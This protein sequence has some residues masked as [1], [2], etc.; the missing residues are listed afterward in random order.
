MTGS[1][2]DSSIQSLNFTLTATNDI[3]E[4]ERENLHT[5]IQKAQC[6]SD[7]TQQDLSVAT[8]ML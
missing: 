2:M 6:L 4:R 8:R 3:T 5:R 7:Y 1:S